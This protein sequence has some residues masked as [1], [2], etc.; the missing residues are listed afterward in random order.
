ML[1]TK[2]KTIFTVIYLALTAWIVT[3]FPT[4]CDIEYEV[5]HPT[6]VYISPANQVLI[7][8]QDNSHE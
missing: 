4:A 8:L 7:E 5:E 6:D 2:S 3:I 1:D